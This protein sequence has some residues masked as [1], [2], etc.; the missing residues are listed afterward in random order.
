M[1]LD[2][3]SDRSVVRNGMQ[4]AED[5]AAVAALAAQRVVGTVVD[6]LVDNLIRL[7]RKQPLV[8]ITVVVVKD[9][10][11]ASPLGQTGGSSDDEATDED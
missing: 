11:L 2:V 9:N 5:A 4:A 3:G 10:N 7:R 6:Q 1:D 8:S